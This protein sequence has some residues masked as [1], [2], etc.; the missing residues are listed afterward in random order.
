MAYS[1][2]G[3]NVMAMK[4]VQQALSPPDT[5]TGTYENTH[6]ATHTYNILKV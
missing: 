5:H 4:S 3:R 2:R 1:F 6:I